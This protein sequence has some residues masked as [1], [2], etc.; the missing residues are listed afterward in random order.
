M[1][2]IQPPASRRRRTAA[3]VIA[4]S[5][6]LAACGSGGSGSASGPATSRAPSTTA[7]GATTPGGDVLP[8]TKNPIDNPSTTPGLSIG[9]VLVENNVDTAGTPVDDHL[10][11]ALSNSGSTELS[12]FE[13]FTT[14]TDPT[15]G[16]SESY[17]AA[18][19]ADFTIPAGGSRVIH[20][21]NTGAPDH[22]PVNDYSL[23]YSSVN[24]LDVEV[25]VSAQGA[26]VQTPTAAVIGPHV[27]VGSDI[28]ARRRPPFAAIGQFCPVCDHGRIGVREVSQCRVGDVIRRRA[29]RPAWREREPR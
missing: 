22:F 5:L 13:V 20:F 19:P 2:P 25:Q 16:T 1:T 3:V 29:S 14:F 21:D 24:A 23:Y 11:I 12:G 27:A 4:A 28:G 15:A 6:A 8:V 10:E 17:Y 18:L 26:A 7:S 9:E